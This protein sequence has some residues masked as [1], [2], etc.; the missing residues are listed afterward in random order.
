MKG[1]II[2]TDLLRLPNL[3]RHVMRGGHRETVILALFRQGMHA[4]T[5]VREN[6]LTALQEATKEGNQYAIGA[7][8][9]AG[10]NLNVP[11]ARQKD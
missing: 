5:S 6:H 9:E 10:A 8:L 3:V 4:D 1:A 2:T 11:V 7:L